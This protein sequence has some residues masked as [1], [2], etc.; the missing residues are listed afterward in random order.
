MHVGVHTAITYSVNGREVEIDGAE[1][2]YHTRSG[3][4]NVEMT[5]YIKSVMEQDIHTSVCYAHTGNSSRH[6]EEDKRE[7]S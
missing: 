3:Q 2:S 4:H 5:D 6:K 7:G 1:D